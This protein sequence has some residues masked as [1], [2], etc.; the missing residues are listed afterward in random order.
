MS[1][2]LC[3]MVGVSPAVAAGRTA[4]I[5]TTV[6][7]AQVSTAQSKF[8][9]AS[10]LFDGTSDGLSVSA[11]GFNVGTNDITIEF[12]V[13]HAAINDQQ[14]Y[15]DFRTGTNSHF[16]FYVRSDNKLELYDGGS[17]YTSTVT[18]ATNTWYHLAISRSGTSLKVY[19]DGTEVMSATN[20]RSLSDNSSIAIGSSYEFTSTNSVNGWIDEFRVSSTARYTAGFTPSATPFTNDVNTLLLLHCNNINGGTTFVDD[21]GTNLIPRTPST[22]TASGNAKISTAQS[23]FGGSSILLDGTDDYL[24]I[25][26]TDNFNFGTTGNFTIEFW[27]YFTSWTAPREVSVWEGR[28]PSG[29]NGSEL[30]FLYTATTL[31]WYVYK[32]SGTRTSTGVP[33]MTANTWQHVALVRNGTNLQIYIDGTARGT[34]STTDSFNYSHA[35]HILIGVDTDINRDGNGYIDEYRVSNVA[36]YT[37]NFTPSGSA[38]VNDSNTVLLIHADGTN[39]ATTFT[40]DNFIRPTS[41]VAINGA[42]LDT[43]QSKF[44][45]SSLLCSSST[46]PQ[47]IFDNLV[48]NA[49]AT[50][51]FTV[52]FFFRTTNLTQSNKV[53]FFT[54]QGGAG[55]RGIQITNQTVR[56]TVDGTDVI[57][58]GNYLTSG[59]WHHIALVRGTN[60]TTNLYIDGT[61]RGS[62][63][64]DTSSFA[65]TNQSRIAGL[66]N[67]F[68]PDGHM[69]ELRI[70]K[71][72]RYTATFTPTT[73]AFVND[74]NTTLLVHFDGTNGSTT[75]TDDNA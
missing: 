57:T 46:N 42:A 50:N 34:P 36:R 19:R 33:Y 66:A 68:T 61:S 31:G 41:L 32:N 17:T 18:M 39:N 63:A 15:C 47:I 1:G 20:S 56:Y 16:I 10:A 49:V 53:L 58:T 40:D 24:T 43:S 7:N 74:A 4:R 3:S 14:V 11:G 62:Y 28:T 54:N 27:I 26:Q 44:G 45:G 60:N 72:A 38:F 75:F 64:S 55:R 71:T 73:A 6:G 69:D 25:A 13:R 48:C 12:W 37:G 65:A 51:P 23:K 21:I 8:G 52:E 22:I 29:S 67:G 30:I 9:G 59:T 70:S 5:V 2:F 35:S